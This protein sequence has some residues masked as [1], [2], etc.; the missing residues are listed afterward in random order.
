M[1]AAGVQT[2]AGVKSLASFAAARRVVEAPKSRRQLNL[3]G[4]TTEAPPRALGEK[5]QKKCW[6]HLAQMTP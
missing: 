6:P 2:K 4:S 3:A 1:E 5:I